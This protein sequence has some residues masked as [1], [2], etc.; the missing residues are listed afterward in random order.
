[1][2]LQLNIF[3]YMK[4]FDVYINQKGLVYRKINSG[5]SGRYWCA[6]DTGTLDWSEQ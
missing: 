4:I 3:K 5:L 2:E 1:M 6:T